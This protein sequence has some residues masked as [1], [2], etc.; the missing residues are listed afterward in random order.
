MLER[1]DLELNALGVHLAFVEL[2]GRLQDLVVRYGL[3]DT[4]DREHF[5]PST[6]DQALEVIDEGEPTEA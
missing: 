3:Y 5:Y 4:L 2:R 1:L 6:L